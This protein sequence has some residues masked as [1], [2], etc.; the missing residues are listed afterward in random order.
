[1]A[2]RNRSEPPKGG[3]SRKKLDLQG[4]R[5]GRLTVLAPAE[6]IQKC[7]AWHCLCDCG[8]KVVAKTRHLRSGHVKSCGC[9]GSPGIGKFLT[10]VDGTCVEMIQAKTVRR[11]NTSGVP[12]VDWR[13]DKRR[14]RAAI[15]FQGK[16][17]YLGS[18]ARFEDAVQA[19]KQAEAELHDAFLDAYAKGEAAEGP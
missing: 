12:G 17:Y 16:R 14:W 9:M 5:W 4:Q 15:C 6:N 3:H 10:Y 1:M 11:N 19:R 8:R 13:A 18:Y 2:G 7:T